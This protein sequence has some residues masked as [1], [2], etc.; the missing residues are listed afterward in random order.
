[1]TSPRLH[2]FAQAFALPTRSARSTPSLALILP[3]GLPGLLWLWSLR[4][5]LPLVIALVMIRGLG[6]F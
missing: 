2:A 6:R 5:A 1:M 4:L 3:A